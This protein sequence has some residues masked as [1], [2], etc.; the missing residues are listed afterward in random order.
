[1][2]IVLFIP[3]AH[4]A[5]DELDSALIL[6]AVFAAVLGGAYAASVRWC[7]APRR[8]HVLFALGT[9]VLLTI[10]GT[11]LMLE[12]SLWYLATAA[13]VYSGWYAGFNIWALKQ[14]YF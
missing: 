1:M 10:F 5:W 11:L 9:A 14:G 6:P 4:R 7:E 2:G 12:R 13:A 8:A 3:V